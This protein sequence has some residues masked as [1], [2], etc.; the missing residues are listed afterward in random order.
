MKTLYFRAFRAVWGCFCGL[1]SGKNQQK[2]NAP[3]KKEPFRVAVGV[4]VFTVK[5]APC[6]AVAVL[7]ENNSN[8]IFCLVWRSCIPI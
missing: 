1:K 4:I 3:L 7:V 5:N 6:G 8:D 2:I